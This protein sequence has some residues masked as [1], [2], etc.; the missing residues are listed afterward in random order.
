M[1]TPETP[2]P[3]A[4]AGWFPAP[5]GSGR[6]RYWDGA[7]WTDATADAA[8]APATG[9]GDD[10]TRMWALAAHLSALV[11]L[12][13]G[14]PFVGPLIV[15]LVKRDDP[16]VRRHAAES[17]N[18]NLSVLIYAF[19]LGVVTV[20]LM[21]VLVGFLLIPLFAVLAIGWLVLVIMASVRASAGEEYRY[22]LTI[23]MVR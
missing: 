10:A 14:L 1:S 18:F 22:P 23:R 7:R 8:S 13:V 19:V 9:G 11:S 2:P 20:I 21:F 6:R 17:L 16:F 12:A 5:D 15:Y 3:A 4:P